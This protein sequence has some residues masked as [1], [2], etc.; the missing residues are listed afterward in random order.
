[1]SA[2]NITTTIDRILDSYVI[3]LM[4][5]TFIKF[6]LISVHLTI[7]SRLAFRIVLSIIF[8]IVIASAIFDFCTEFGPLTRYRK[9]VGKFAWTISFP[10]QTF[11]I[12]S[13]L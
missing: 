6:W 1:M 11:Q 12:F 3:I 9:G 10:D 7:S 13:C 4:I 5:K 2:S 8:I